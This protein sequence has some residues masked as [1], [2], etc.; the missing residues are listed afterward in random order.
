MWIK[1]AN[2]SSHTYISESHTIKHQQGVN[3][4]NNEIKA[5]IFNRAN[6]THTHARPQISYMLAIKETGISYPIYWWFFCRLF[7]LL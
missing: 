6:V 1:H 2:I 4:I 5:I 3:L 7:L